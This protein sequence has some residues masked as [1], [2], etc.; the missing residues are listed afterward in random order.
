MKEKMRTVDGIKVTKTGMEF[1]PVDVRV[2]ADKLGKTMSLAM[3]DVMIIIPI[4]PVSDRVR[5]GE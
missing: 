2:T 5:I 4:E 1:A 3:G